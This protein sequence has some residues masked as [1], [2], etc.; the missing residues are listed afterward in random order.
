MVALRLNDVA[1]DGTS[2]RVS[3]GMLNLSQR[4]DRERVRTMISG[5]EVEVRV[6]AQ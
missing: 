5:E 3:Y 4:E 6:Q 2:L 1:P